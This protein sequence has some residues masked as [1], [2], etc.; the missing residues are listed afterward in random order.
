MNN[1]TF[2]DTS[3]G[4]YETIAGGAGAGPTWHGASG[5]HTHMTNTRITDPEILER[6]YPVLLQA[7]G[8]RRGSGGEGKFRG[9]DGV[10]RSLRFRR[11]LTVSILSERRALKPFGLMGGADA[12]R[13]LN[14]LTVAKSR[15]TVS[16]GGKN[17]VNVSP[18]DVLSILTP[19]GGGYG[20]LDVRSLA[21]EANQEE[22][23]D[24][25]E[26]GSLLWVGAGHATDKALPPLAGSEMRY[27]LA[28]E[29]A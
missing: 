26:G 20:K 5:V 7:F 1:L 8:L 16:L 27:K 19:G 22:H 18:G 12:A 25:K 6:R 14:L 10:V 4:Y 28:Q 9:G 13:G 24:E 29:Q 2:G 11:P 17:T 21:G 15:K 23:E 3:M